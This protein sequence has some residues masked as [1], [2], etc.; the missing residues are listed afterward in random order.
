[1]ARADGGV[2]G[3]ALYFLCFKKVPD[4]LGYPSE[5]NWFSS[6]LRAKANRSRPSP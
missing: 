2:R 3:G 5:A 1:M 6:D 4:H